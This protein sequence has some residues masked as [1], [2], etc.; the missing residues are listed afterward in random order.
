MFQPNS[1]KTHFLNEI[2]LQIL[3]CLDRAP[4]SE[5]EVC[6]FLTDQFQLVLDQNFSQQTIKTLH[7]FE[8]LGLIE[9]VRPESLI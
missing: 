8:E 5:D 4:A 6:V 3:L 9:K 1:G 2:G 7:R